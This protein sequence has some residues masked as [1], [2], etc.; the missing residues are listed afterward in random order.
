[1]SQNRLRSGPVVTSPRKT[2]TT[3]NRTYHRRTDG[4]S[5]EEN[6]LH[7]FELGASRDHLDETIFSI[8]GLQS[9]QT[10]GTAPLS[11]GLILTAI[12]AMKRSISCQQPIN[13]WEAWNG[14]QRANRFV[15][16]HAAEPAFGEGIDKKVHEHLPQGTRGN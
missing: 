13:P 8:L 9:A 2:K 15:C 6:I 16:V 10:R 4:I 12:R 1:M 3:T 7:Q 5:A 11:L 14:Y